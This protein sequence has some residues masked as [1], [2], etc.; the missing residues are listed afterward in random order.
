MSLP[1]RIS[2]GVIVGLSIAVLFAAFR[3]RDSNSAPTQSSPTHRY[4]VEY[5]AIDYSGEVRTDAVSELGERLARGEA[6]LVFEDAYQRGY[7]AS[8]LEALGIDPD[9]QTLVFSRTSAQI[10]YI[11]PATPR[12]IYY[13]DDVYVA[14]PPNAP[15]I[16]IAA[17]DPNLGP[18][19]YTLDQDRGEI[20]L[21][22]QM[23]ECL[24]CHDSYSLTGGG[25][26]RF[27]LG[28]GFT[29]ARGEQVTH[30]GW[31]L[32]DDRTPLNFRWGGWYV[33]GTH[34]EQTHMGN[35][36]IRDP[37]E[38]RDMDLTRTGN[39]TDLGE[40]IPVEPYVGSHSDIVALMVLDHQTHVQNVMTRVNFDSRTLLDETAE[41]TAGA[42]ELPAETLARIESIAEPLVEVLLLV[43]EAALSGRIEGT[44]GFADSFQAKGPR[45][46]SGRSFRELDLETRLFRYPCS[47]LIYSAAFDA[48]PDPVRQFVYR[49][50]VEILSGE[51]TSPAFA[52]LTPADRN[53]ILEILENT[54][55]EFTSRRI[56]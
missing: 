10:P 44:S 25:V 16:E 20:R 51:D 23:N 19:F 17:M 5:P 45:D 14:W 29:D 13:N 56:G 30:E 38:L 52:H 26:P 39:L 1:R 53:A 37:A 8:L 22:R 9:S 6:R 55:P 54:K 3:Q 18:V 11:S 12:A 40:L 28:S 50:F 43:D 21:E 32:V 48:L 34:L 36:V 31:I 47:Y 15:E 33:T 35:W 42:A 24:R 27:I 41:T 4:D 7:L 46:A 49:R 2:N